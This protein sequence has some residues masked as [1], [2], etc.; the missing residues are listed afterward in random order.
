MMIKQ[1]KKEKKSKKK[2]NECA[3]FIYTYRH[4][5][6]DLQSL[7]NKYMHVHCVLVGTQKRTGKKS[8]KEK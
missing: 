4:L 6:I 7:Q 5:C 2:I 1:K 8:A 3:C